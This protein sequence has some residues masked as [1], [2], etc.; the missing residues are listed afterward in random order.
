MLITFSHDYNGQKVSRGA[1]AAIFHPLV[2]DCDDLYVLFVEADRQTD[3]AG[4][5][6]AAASQPA[7]TA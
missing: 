3:S 2:E 5:T 6:P 1:H 7:T 4:R